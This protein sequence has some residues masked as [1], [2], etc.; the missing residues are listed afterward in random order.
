MSIKWDK[1]K[2]EGSCPVHSY[3]VH[4]DDGDNGDLL[5]IDDSNL[6]CESAS[7]V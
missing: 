3:E 7:Y 4:M 5:K 6:D 2:D 1:P